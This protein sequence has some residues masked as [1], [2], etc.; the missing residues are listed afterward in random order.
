MNLNVTTLKEVWYLYIN[1]LPKKKVARWTK[2]LHVRPPPSEKKKFAVIN[3]PIL[4][5]IFPHPVKSTMARLPITHT[6][7][8]AHRSLPLSCASARARARPGNQDARFG[9][10]GACQRLLF[11]GENNKP[12][13]C[14]FYFQVCAQLLYFIN[15]LYCIYF[16]LGHTHTCML[17][18]CVT[19][20]TQ[21]VAPPKHLTSHPS[22]ETLYRTSTS[23]QTPEFLPKNQQRQRIASCVT[24]G[25]SVSLK[26]DR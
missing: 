8:P 2:I 21:W 26:E 6:Q 18:V 24:Q 22:H 3:F 14:L 13:L 12:T 7:D 9:W 19:V 25:K 20:I 10:V 23:L 17:S 11:G 1:F 5:S 16:T 15:P 4:E